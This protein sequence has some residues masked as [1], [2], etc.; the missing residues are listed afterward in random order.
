MTSVKGM[1]PDGASLE[2]LKLPAEVG[3]DQVGEIERVSKSISWKY[4]TEFMLD[5]IG[6]PEGVTQEIPTH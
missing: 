1:D 3:I 4:L 6:Y 5:V 2:A